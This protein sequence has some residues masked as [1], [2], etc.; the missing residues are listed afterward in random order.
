MGQF[1][2][3]VHCRPNGDPFYVGKGS[4]RRAKML[5]NRRNVFHQN[6]VS[7]FGADSIEVVLIPFESEAHAFAGEVAAIHLLRRAGYELTNATDGGE[8]P[9][10]HKH[11]EETRHLISLAN[12]LRDYSGRGPA[13][14]KALKGR[15]G[16]MTGKKHSEETRARMRAAHLAA[17]SRGMAGKKHSPETLALMR[18]RAQERK[19]QK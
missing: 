5:R 15:V 3:Y 19:E 17:P 2:V 18:Q 7:K 11:S 13:L 10:G 6:V 4:L 12:T 14:S 16:G 1:Y 9:T 8:G